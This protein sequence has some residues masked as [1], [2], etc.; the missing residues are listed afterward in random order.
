MDKLNP[1][2]KGIEVK[3]HRAHGEDDN[4][5]KGYTLE[6][7]RHHRALIAVKKEFAKAKVL[8]NFEIIKDYNPFAKD[9]SLKAAARLGTLPLK[10]VKGLNYTDYIMLGLSAFSTG[11]KFFSFFR[12]KK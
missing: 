7:I 5:F 4:E 3:D 2:L 10:I 6:E 12:K 1:S 8:E 11:R 9:G